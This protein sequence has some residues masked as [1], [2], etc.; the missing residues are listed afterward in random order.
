MARRAGVAE[1][2]RRS[3]R[4]ERVGI[5]TLD[6]QKSGMQLPGALFYHRFKMLA[7]CFYLSFEPP[8]MQRT[9]QAGNNH[10]FQ[11]RFCEIVVGAQAHRLHAC[12]QVVYTCG[13]DES[14]VWMPPASLRQK[15]HPTDTR[16][17]KVRNNGVELLTLQS[18]QSFFA[19]V[20]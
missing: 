2:N 20:Y 13:H 3:E 9:L 16:H 11:K 6:L 4:L 15:F 8:L 5:T 14:D 12:F 19:I 18:D 10:A 17:A 1:I 7:I